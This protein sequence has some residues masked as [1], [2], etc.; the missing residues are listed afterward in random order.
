MKK[1]EVINAFRKPEPGRAKETEL[2][3]YPVYPSSED[4]YNNF[5]QEEDIN[6]EDLTKTKAA[7]KI[8]SITKELGNDTFEN[9]T[10]SDLDVPGAELDDAL[11]EV[12]SEDEENNYYSLGGD[13]HNDLDENKGD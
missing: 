4:I 2:P 9:K 13:D 12:G 8:K 7:N 5:K 3:G 10:G 1:H 6:P 11:E